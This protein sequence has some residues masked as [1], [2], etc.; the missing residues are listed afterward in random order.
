MSLN[1]FNIIPYHNTEIDI[2][3]II[4]NVQMP[5]DIKVGIS[6]KSQGVMGQLLKKI[7]Y[8]QHEEK[9]ISIPAKIAIVLIENSRVESGLLDISLVGEY[10]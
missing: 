5:I 7:N 3:D 8:P 9:P 1:M 4:K 2:Y 6:S 10:L